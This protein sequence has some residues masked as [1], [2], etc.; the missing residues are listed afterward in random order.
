MLTKITVSSKAQRLEVATI[1]EYWG[2]TASLQILGR[3]DWEEVLEVSAAK[4]NFR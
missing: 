4:K 2:F 3:Q 1:Q